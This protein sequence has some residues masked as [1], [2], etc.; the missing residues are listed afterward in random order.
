MIISDLNNKNYVILDTE[1]TGIDENA[2]ILQISIINEKNEVL[3]NEFVKPLR[4][5]SW[6]EAEKI[7]KISPKQVENKPNISVF[8]SKILDIL[9]NADFIVGYNTSYDLRLL[10]QSG[11]NLSKNIYDKSVDLMHEFALSQGNNIPFSNQ[12]INNKLIDCAKYY[13]YSQDKNNSFHDSLEDCRATLACFKANAAEQMKKQGFIHLDEIGLYNTFFNSSF[14][15]SKFS[16]QLLKILD[17]L[18][19]SPYLTDDTTNKTDEEL[20]DLIDFALYKYNKHHPDGPILEY[21]NRYNIVT[22]KDFFGNKYSLGSSHFSCPYCLP[23]AHYVDDISESFTEYKSLSS[24]EYNLDIKFDLKN[25]DFSLYATDDNFIVFNLDDYLKFTSINTIVDNFNDFAVSTKY[26]VAND[27][28]CAIDAKN[29][30]LVKIFAPEYFNLSDRYDYDIED[31]ENKGFVSL[32]KEDFLTVSKEILLDLALYGG[33][34]NIQDLKDC[35]DCSNLFINKLNFLSIYTPDLSLLPRTDLEQIEKLFN[36]PKISNI[37]DVNSVVSTMDEDSFIYLNR[38]LINHKLDDK[39]FDIEDKILCSAKDLQEGCTIQPQDNGQLI[40][41][42]K[43]TCDLKGWDCDLN[44]I[45]TSKITNMSCLFAADDIGFNLGLEKFNGDISKWNTSNVTNM[46]FMFA[47]TKNFNQPL[48][49]WNTSN[50]KN[51]RGMFNEADSFNQPLD[52]WDVSN[53]TDMSDMFCY[54][55]SF[56]QPLNKWNISSNIQDMYSMFFMAES[57][58]QSLNRWIVPS[59]CD[60][61]DMF[62]LANSFKSELPDFK[63]YSRTEKELLED[64][65]L[66]PDFKPE[67]KK[68]QEQEKAHKKSLTR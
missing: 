48:N 9:N 3:L 29:Q 7:N 62:S 33:A 24:N 1:T 58:N 46:S 16:P 59:N 23:F 60:F 32:K 36:L 43:Q 20:E 68:E 25:Q 11:I 31:F 27:T 44:F 10:E 67:I 64:L 19:D 49:N 53:V 34:Y 35:H 38:Y 12:L 55:K 41:I 40:R 45:D 28:V 6:D 22:C 17:K 8:S 18:T 26:T 50:V 39:I 2:E 56:N 15:S 54:A 57:F 42:I 61:N 52:N 14:S 37:D 51:M 21:D 66:L 30:N 65:G 63:N 47:G 4:A 13:G 5:K